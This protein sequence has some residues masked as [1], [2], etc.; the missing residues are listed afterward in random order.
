MEMARLNRNYLPLTI[1]LFCVLFG[2]TKGQWLRDDI[3]LNVTLLE[4]IS[5]SGEKVVNTNLLSR[6]EKNNSSLTWQ[7]G[8]LLWEE[9][10]REKAL[11]VWKQFPRYSA[12]MLLKNVEIIG[13]TNHQKL[14]AAL[15]L[16]PYSDE[17]SEYASFY[18][19][20]KGENALIYQLFDKVYQQNPDNAIAMMVLALTMQPDIGDTSRALAL[21]DKALLQSPENICVIR[22][23]FRV[24]NKY[25]IGETRI[26]QLIQVAEKQLPLPDFEIVFALSNAYNRLGDYVSAERYNL[27]ALN[28]N[29]NHPWANLQLVENHQIQGKSDIQPWLNRAIKFR[30]QSRP[31]YYKRLIAV[32]LA[33]ND[34]VTAKKILCEAVENG[35]SPQ[36]IQGGNNITI[37]EAIFSDCG[38]LY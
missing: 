36:S 17:V 18:L 19:L 38:D 7:Y 8:Y 23:G 24:M 16:D 27:M 15:L 22:Y 6:I 26:R 10:E 5:P 1:I 29:P 30:V 20:Q 4:L 9:G 11:N 21:F 13:D 34:I 2:V 14:K 33:S 25:D 31:D 3:F 12:A 37:D 32:L 35:N 28:I